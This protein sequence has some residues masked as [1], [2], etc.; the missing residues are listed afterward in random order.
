MEAFLSAIDGMN[1]V[2]TERK[3]RETLALFRTGLIIVAVRVKRVE[4]RDRLK[5][6]CRR[7]M[8]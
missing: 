4:M 2:A 3:Q 1:E 7:W 5:R 8:R 6:F